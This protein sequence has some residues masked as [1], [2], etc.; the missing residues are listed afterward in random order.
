MSIQSCQRNVVEILKISNQKN[1]KK[2]IDQKRSFRTLATRIA[3]PGG[4]GLLMMVD[5]ARADLRAFLLVALKKKE[6][7]KE[8]IVGGK[9]TIALNRERGGRCLVFADRVKLSDIPDLGVLKFRLFLGDF[10]RVRSCCCYGH[11]STTLESLLSCIV[12]RNFSYQFVYNFLESGLNISSQ[13]V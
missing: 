12:G 3:P 7:K 5:Y 11:H 6:E 1:G 9:K 10:Q 2:I 8:I 13:V 4:K